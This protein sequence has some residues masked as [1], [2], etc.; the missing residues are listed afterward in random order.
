[1]HPLPEPVRH[2]ARF[3]ALAAL[4]VGLGLF[5]IGAVKI[6]LTLQLPAEMR[7][8]SSAYID[9][10]LAQFDSA[11]TGA[12]ITGL[13]CWAA[14]QRARARI[15]TRP[16]QHA[17][18]VA[19]VVML[20][21]LGLEAITPLLEPL[22]MGERVG[23]REPEDMTML[24]RFYAFMHLLELPLIAALAFATSSALGRDGPAPTMPTAAWVRWTHA[25][26]FALAAGTA[27]QWLFAAFWQLTMGVA[28]LDAALPYMR[29]GSFV[30]G[31]GPCLLAMLPAAGWAARHRVDALRPLH[32]AGLGALAGLI[33]AV[34]IGIGALAFIAI[35]AA[36][37]SSSMADHGMLIGLGASTLT[38][39]GI[40]ALL[41]VV[42]MHGHVRLGAT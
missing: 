35:L 33:M 28:A 6:V 8:P 38:L 41:G 27:L 7:L 21:I 22:A 34:V 12:L 40:G 14:Q 16:Q 4:G 13:A 9:M 30:L 39:L 36:T 3:P 2:L 15:G 37:A 29:V 42:G 20:A 10:V 5:G 17:G 32:A 26:A 31:W 24:W 23:M 1:M 25:A 11:L 18:I 19:I